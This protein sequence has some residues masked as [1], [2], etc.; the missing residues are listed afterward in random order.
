MLEPAKDLRQSFPQRGPFAF[1]PLDPVAQ[2]LALRGALLKA[3]FRCG[4]GR[5]HPLMLLDETRHPELQLFE[6][7]KVHDTNIEQILNK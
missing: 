7:V 3:R 4:L 1:V 2:A 6:F 5:P